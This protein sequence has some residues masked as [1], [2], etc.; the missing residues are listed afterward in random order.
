MEAVSY[1]AQWTAAARAL[2]SER[3]DRLFDDPYAR[4]LAGTEGFSLLDR[5][6]GAGTLTFLAIRTNYIDGKALRLAHERAIRQVVFV[7]AGMDTRAYRLPWPDT[8]TVFELDR[9]ALLDAKAELLAASGDPGRCDRRAV[10]VDLAGEWADDL[11]A[12]GMRPD[13][14]TLWV[15]EGLLFFLPEQAVC[16]LLA[17]MRA[18]STA[19]SVLIGDVASRASL[20]NPLAGKFLR[21]LAAD[22]APW[23]FGTDDPAGFLADCGWAVTDLKQPGEEGAAFGRW[24]YP[25]PPSEVPNVPR[26]FLFT[27]D[28][29]AGRDS[30]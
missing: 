23:Q 10:P 5:Y 3:Q 29:S 21:A 11:R 22:G 6:V 30:A 12:A 8:M 7:A 19:D 15:M 2:E 9:P 16:R 17:T 18:L 26:S 25:V 24:P 27:A 1:T 4:T 28:P 20:T 13:Q 14:P